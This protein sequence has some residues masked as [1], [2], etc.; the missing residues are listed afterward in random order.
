MKIL[1]AL[2]TFALL[3][4]IGQLIIDNGEGKDFFRYDNALP[5]TIVLTAIVILVKALKKPK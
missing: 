4:S 1:K 5:V 3:L 2:F